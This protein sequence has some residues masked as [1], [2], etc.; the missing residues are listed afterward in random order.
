MLKKWMNK[1]MTWGGY[2]KFA[3]IVEAIAAIA[4]GIYF[5]WTFW[6]NFR[7]GVYEFF[8]KLKHPLRSNDFELKDK[9]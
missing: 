3:I 5:M 1:P 6:D 8:S 4:G 9:G 7:I 2:F